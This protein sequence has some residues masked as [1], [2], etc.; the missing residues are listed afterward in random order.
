[1]ECPLTPGA[2][3]QLAPQ[4]QGNPRFPRSACFQSRKPHNRRDRRLSRLVAHQRV[5][6]TSRDESQYFLQVSVAQLDRASASEAEGCWFDSSREHFSREMRQQAPLVSVLR[7]VSL[8][9]SPPAPICPQA[10]SRDRS[11]HWGT[12]MTIPDQ[13][14]LDFGDVPGHASSAPRATRNAPPSSSPAFIASP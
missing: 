5:E 11:A 6:L 7:V 10:G 9:F 8:L 3:L 13:I 12:H 4:I 14:V 2:V 1:M